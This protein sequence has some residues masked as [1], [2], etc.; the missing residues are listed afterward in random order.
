MEL[1]TLTWPAVDLRR[2]RLILHD[3]KNRERRAVPLVGHARELVQQLAQVRRQDAPF[4][5]P[6]PDGR[7]PLRLEYA[8]QRARQQ[9]EL[10]D[11][12][13]HDL[14]HSTASYLAMNGASLM[15][16]AVM[17]GHKTLDMVRR[18]AHLT[19]AHVDSVVRKMNAKIFGPG[20]P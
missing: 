1:L 14:R 10:P 6:R 20:V 4:L 8:W 3:T 17:L 2:G 11:F 9:A 13:F 12:R 16:I 15:D 5:F 7:K 19:D 18:Y